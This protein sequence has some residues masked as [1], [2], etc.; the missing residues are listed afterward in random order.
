MKISL[1]KLCIRGLVVLSLIVSVN[2]AFA[3]DVTIF[4]TS[5][6]PFCKKLEAYLKDH[7]VHYQRY[8]I[9]QSAE[10]RRKHQALG[11]GGVPVV[12][13]GSTVVRGFDPSYL[14]M[15]LA[16]PKTRIGTTT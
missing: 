9:E 7:Q 4:V 11:G 8:D 2:S 6:C 14:D 10:G 1:I 5:W 3:E 15:L 12:Q 13:I 16:H